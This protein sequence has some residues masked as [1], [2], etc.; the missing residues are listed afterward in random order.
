[1]H[2]TCCLKGEHVFVCVCSVWVCLV[3]YGFWTEG[4][5][6]YRWFL[7]REKR[8]CGLGTRKPWRNFWKRN[9]RKLGQCG[10]TDPQGPDEVKIVKTVLFLSSFSYS[11]RFE[12]DNNITAWGEKAPD[13][14]LLLFLFFFFW[15]KWVKRVIVAV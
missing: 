11:I 4:L 1:M 10:D 8:V 3:L 2:L 14:T 13:K 15:R 7:N 12:D 6:Y 9:F 5:L